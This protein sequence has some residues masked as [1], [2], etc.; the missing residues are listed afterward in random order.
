MAFQKPPKIC[1]ICKQGKE[2]KF[3]RDFKKANSKF[4][5]YQCSECSVQFWLPLDVP[6]LYWYEEKNFRIKNI[7][8]PEICRGYHK[9]F[10]KIHK[11]FPKGTRVLDLGC[12][13]GEFIAKIEKRGCEVWGVDFDKENIKVAKEYFGLEKVFALSFKEFFQKKGL[14]KFDIISFLAV[15]GY[16]DD[17]LEFFRNIKNLLKPNGMVVL[18]APSRERMLVDLNDWDFPP[19]YFTRWNK[20]SVLNIF[21]KEGFNISRIDY[22]EQFKTLLEGITSNFKT[23]LVGKSII[24]S[25]NKQGSLIFLKI[26]Y[27]LGCLKYYAIGIIPAMFLWV[28][29][30]ISK[31]NNGTMLIELTEIRSPQTYE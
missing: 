13:A 22:V 5:L 16:L 15:I 14:P 12:A 27:F 25:K 7:I 2:F 26:V 24:I 17:P 30:K 19:H 4:S 1:P 18:N 10:L 20:Q 3:I 8:K 31:R 23:G 28:I 9:K 6:G 21:Q 11:T 29:G